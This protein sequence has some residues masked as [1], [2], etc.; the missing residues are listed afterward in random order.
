[1]IVDNDN[2]WKIQRKEWTSNPI[3]QFMFILP[4]SRTLGLGGLV[5]L[6]V[7]IESSEWN[8]INGKFFNSRCFSRQ[9]FKNLL[10]VYV[11]L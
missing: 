3:L 6:W 2:D 11:V 1:M 7:S 10:F 5:K 9:F 8:V 4:L